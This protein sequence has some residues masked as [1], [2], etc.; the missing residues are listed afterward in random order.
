MKI[1]RFRTPDGRHSL[2][3]VRGDRVID[4]RF[5]WPTLSRRVGL[6]APED[7]ASFGQM[8]RLGWLRPDIAS[9]LDR[10]L[11]EIELG[12]AHA[13]FDEL[14]PIPV[15]DPE[16]QVYC[17]A[18]NFARHAAERG[19]DTP[20][21]PVLFMKPRTSV[22]GHTDSIRIR[23]DIGQV[24]HEAEVAAVIGAT[25]TGA[26]EEQATAGICGYTCLNDITAR[27]M[28]K[29]FQAKSWP[30]LLAKGMDTFCP[31]GPWIVT[32]DEFGDY[33]NHSIVCRVN[34]AIRQQGS[35]SEMVFSPGQVISYL[36]QHVSLY[37]GDIVALGTPEGIGPLVPGDT[38]EVE[39]SGIGI[40]RNPVE[41][42]A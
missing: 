17:V 24:D 7:P 32:A 22:I 5:Y 8:L 15:I 30:W 21:Q 9:T 41:R 6:E 13:R 28:Q 35:L 25:L 14:N 36:S 4:L 2:G 39:A 29:G 42:T 38:V 11:D 20:D 40:L 12:A 18:R 37:P 27:T 33:K 10:T 3:I 34:G 19:V 31:V 23:E 1:T 16:S 26:T